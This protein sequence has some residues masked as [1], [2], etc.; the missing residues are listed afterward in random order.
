MAENYVT[1]ITI[2]LTPAESL[3]VLYV[4][5]EKRNYNPKD[6]PLAD[7][8]RKKIYEKVKECDNNG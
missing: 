7:R 5:S 1:N 8:V 6:R 3:L 4:L 2:T